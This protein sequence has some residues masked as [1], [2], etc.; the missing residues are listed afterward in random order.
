MLGKIVRNTFH[1]NSTANFT[2][3]LHYEVL[4]CG[5]PKTC[6]TSE[7]S[8]RL[9]L[10]LGLLSGAHEDNL[11]GPEKSLGKK[12]L[13]ARPALNQSISKATSWPEPC[14]ETTQ[15]IVPTSVIGLLVKRPVS[16]FLTSSEELLDLLQVLPAE[17]QGEG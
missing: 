6:R 3:K 2:I 14:V 9:W 16:A 11:Q 7:S 13:K 10:L 4:G 1:Q 17:P 8:R 5:V 12:L 15:S